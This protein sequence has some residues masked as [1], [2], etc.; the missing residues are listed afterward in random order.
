LK[1]YLS[2]QSAR[3]LVVAAAVA[4]V[5]AAAAADAA[6][7]GAAV[8]AAVAHV[9]QSPGA[10]RRLGEDGVVVAVAVVLVAVG[11]KPAEVPCRA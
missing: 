9:A 7:V 3:L 8:V 11:C 10:G 2:H 4:A 5:A 1:A 6:A